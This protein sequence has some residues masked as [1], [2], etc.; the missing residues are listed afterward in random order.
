[1][2]RFY[3]PVW[4]ANPRVQIALIVG[5]LVLI[6]ITGY[7]AVG[8][9]YGSWEWNKAQTAIRSRDFKT[10]QKHLAA[11]MRE[12]PDSAET[13]FA[14][15][16]IARRAGDLDNAKR[17]LKTAKDL[18][19]IPEQIDVEQSLIEVQQGNFDPVAGFLLR[20]E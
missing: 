8:Y 3:R 10:A 15:A 11:C 4:L 12:W 1:M 9:L 5:L 6:G 17:L 19:W 14:A 16:R 2:S 7:P 13:A 18:K 20:S